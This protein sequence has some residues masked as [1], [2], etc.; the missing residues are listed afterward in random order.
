VPEAVGQLAQGLQVHP[1]QRAPVTPEP[2]LLSHLLEAIDAGHDDLCG[3]HRQANR[4]VTNA[5][6][7][8]AKFRWGWRC[9]RRDVASRCTSNGRYQPS[10]RTL[11]QSSRL[12]I[13]GDRLIFNDIL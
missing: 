12:T 5:V 11:R 10:V 4:Y 8:L 6:E 3:F 9:R 13:D 2:L 7:V 1:A